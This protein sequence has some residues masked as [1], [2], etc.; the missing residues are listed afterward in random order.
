MLSADAPLFHVDCT[1]QMSQLY[2]KSIMFIIVKGKGIIA[3]LYAHVKG[4]FDM[5]D[6][7]KMMR[8][9]D[10]IMLH[11]GIISKHFNHAW[12]HSGVALDEIIK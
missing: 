4:F 8:F 12:L 6:Q 5:C 2:D 7:N 1:R 10:F 11:L 3:F 9:N